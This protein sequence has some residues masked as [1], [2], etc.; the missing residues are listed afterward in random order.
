MPGGRPGGAGPRMGGD[1]GVYRCPNGLCQ[2]LDAPGRAL[3]PCRGCT[4]GVG[5][6]RE[7]PVNG[8]LLVALLVGLGVVVWVLGDGLTG[9]DGPPSPGPT[10]VP[11]PP[12]GAR[13]RAEPLPRGEVAP[14]VVEPGAAPEPVAAA[15]E[16]P[17]AAVSPAPAP[18]QGADGPEPSGDDAAAATEGDPFAFAATVRG[19]VLDDS[20]LPLEGVELSLGAGRTRLRLRTRE[21]GWFLFEEIPPMALELTCTASR[22]SMD[23]VALEPAPY[24]DVNLGDL[25]VVRRV[26]VTV[27]LVDPEGA[28]VGGRHKLVAVRVGDEAATF[29]LILDRARPYGGDRYVF[30]NLSPGEYTILDLE[31]PEGREP[32]VR[33]EL[34]PG[35]P[36]LEVQL[37]IP[38]DDEG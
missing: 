18:P 16:A 36:D 12:A 33:L 30:S 2:R 1:P 25:V 5:D 32:R 27:E 3:G 4:V 19:R 22:W 23:A 11:P 15:A 20:G 6:P 8:R 37:V 26:R 24:E 17:A 28:P 34:Q 14:P 29:G 35:S 9:G 21:G 31:G 10:T 7:D 38:D 13:A